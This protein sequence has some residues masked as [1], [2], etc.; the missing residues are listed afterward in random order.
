MCLSE[1]M[2]LCSGTESLQVARFAP[3]RQTSQAKS[4]KGGALDPALCRP[5]EGGD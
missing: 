2:K 5:L 1:L 4:V 3:Y